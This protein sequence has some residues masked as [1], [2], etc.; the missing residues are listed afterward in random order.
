[1]DDESTKE[2]LAECEI[3]RGSAPVG[4]TCSARVPEG[5]LYHSRL[6]FTWG[7]DDTATC[8][9]MNFIPYHY[10]V[11]NT[12]GFIPTYK[13]GTTTI[14]CSAS[15]INA[16]CFN[17][18]GKSIVPNFPNNV[19]F[20]FLTN[21]QTSMTKTTSSAEE[22][23]IFTNRYTVND[24]ADQITDIPGHFVGGSM[25]NYTVECRDEWNDLQYEIVFTLSDEDSNGSGSTPGGP[26]TG[27]TPGSGPTNHYSD[28][29]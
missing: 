4:T 29:N 20:F 22:E 19:G 12:A 5:Q 27:E 15:P 14:D 23:K 13:G 2:T 10:Q 18:V 26:P 11:S 7:T 1:M 28:W 24:L 8:R 6:S 9:V 25:H 21:A 3:L 16:D 17:G